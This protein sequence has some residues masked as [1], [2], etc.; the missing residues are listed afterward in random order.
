VLYAL[1]GTGEV[2][3]WIGVVTAL[4]AATM[5]LAT[6]DIKAVLAYSTISQLGY[7]FVGVGLGAY[8]AGIAHLM[9]H[10][11]FKGLLFLGAGSAL[12]AMRDELDIRKMGGLSK[13]MPLTFWTFLIA[14]C[15]IAGVPFLSGFFSKD[16]ILVAAWQHP[17]IFWIGLATAA[18][19][20]FYMFRLVAVAFLG[21]PRDYSLYVH[22]HE[23][24]PAM[25]LPLLALAVLSAGGGLVWLGFHESGRFY[26]FLAEVFHGE[27]HAGGAGLPFVLTA[28]LWVL[29]PAFALF[30]V[31]AYVGRSAEAL[32]QANAVVRVLRRKYYVDELYDVIVV[33]P[34][35]WVSDRVLWRV[36]DV[37]I[38]DGLVNFAASVF[39]V[40]GS[41]LRMWQTGSVQTY[42][43]AIL[44][45]L[46]A[47]LMGV[48]AL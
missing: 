10:A 24:P 37:G 31:R 15:A 1:A 18:L 29:G 41:A 19:T 28:A 11:F 33:R 46:V 26:G 22:V 3:A 30:G 21:E 40:G 12:H 47:L 27:G 25:T 9:T 13:K 20:A 6:F 5:A 36:V 39:W 17:P 4:F 34:V 45:G 43:I 32:S 44:A 38:I 7:M 48:L 35:R 23:S 14:A 16:A 2:V 42:A 8:S